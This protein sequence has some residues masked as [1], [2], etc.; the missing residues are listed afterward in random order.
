LAS[1]VT[2]VIPTYN[3]AW[4]IEETIASVF[5]QTYPNVEIIVVDDASTDD[6]SVRLEPYRDRIRYLRHRRNQGKRLGDPA[7][8]RNTGIR[9]A[10]GEFVAFL[11]GDDLWEPEKLAIQIDTAHRYPQAGLL[12]VDGIRF[13]HED[14]R[15]LRDSL[16]VDPGDTLPVGEV[17]TARLYHRFLQ[18]CIIE[19]PSQVMVRA[20]VL[21]SI[22]GFA[23]LFS[24][25][26]D[27]YLRVAA[28]YE[29][30]LIKRGLIRYRYR[31]SN[32]SGP[33]ER[34]HFRFA[35]AN[36]AI[37]KKQL[38]V[39]HPDVR[40]LLDERIGQELICIGQQALHDGLNGNRLW[41]SKYLCVLF[42]RNMRWKASLSLLWYLI[43][44]WYPWRLRPFVRPI[45]HSHTSLVVSRLRSLKRERSA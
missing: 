11:D 3:Q 1:L 13:H 29:V 32:C 31:P 43:Q 16:F 24:S 17:L 9:N 18:G 4:C 5:S 30:A 21:R 7:A 2:V 25:D 44:L 14:G 40:P 6:T 45:S 39:A 36:I 12:I 8:A 23:S 26:Y 35:P 10:H 22:G 42:L 19:T 27:F 15:R 37:W 20:S 38:R 34:Q 28:R 41:A 33:L